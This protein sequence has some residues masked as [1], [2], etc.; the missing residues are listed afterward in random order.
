M[1]TADIFNV[2]RVLKGPPDATGKPE[3]EYTLRKP[4]Q[5]EQ[6]EFQRWLEQRAHDAVDRSSAPEAAKD[7]RHHAIDVDAGLG[8]YE[9]DGELG[10]AARFT[11]AGMVKIIA[12][13]LRD[14][15]LTEA[16]AE[17]VVAH[18]VR[19][20]ALELIEK[21]ESDPNAVRLARIA[22][23][24]GR[25][26][27]PAASGSS[28]SSCATRPSAAPPTSP[29]SAGSPTTSCSSSTPSSAAPTG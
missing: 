3:W 17:P 10:L 20:I 29:P 2:G 5:Y 22:L 1:T 15:G 8:K 11:P 21:E 18:C 24:L 26:N 28:S 7:R 14:Q 4:T 9:Y 23:G 13:V 19:E 16:T 27:D 12:I 6:G 25:L